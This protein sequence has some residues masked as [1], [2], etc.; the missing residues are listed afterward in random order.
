MVK[1]Y[2]I[3]VVNFDPARGAEKRGVRPALILQNN[4]VN[5]SKI[6]TVI[7]VPLTNTPK[8]VPSAVWI[9]ASK[10]NGLKSDSR[11]EISQLRMIDRRRISK[12]LGTLEPKYYKD[13]SEKVT[14]FLDLNDEYL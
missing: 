12:T 9:I 8:D 7:V 6:E 4:K 3:V 11:L 5:Q 2:D 13:I 14:N 10:E 1:K